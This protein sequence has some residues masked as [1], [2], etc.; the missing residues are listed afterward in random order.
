MRIALKILFTLFSI[1]TLFLLNEI[2]EPVPSSTTV[3]SNDVKL[4]KSNTI[5]FEVKLD[6][7]YQIELIPINEDILGNNYKLKVILNPNPTFL[8]KKNNVEIKN[9][10]FQLG[11]FCA[12]SGDDFELSINELDDRLR[13]KNMK[14]LITDYDAMPS[15]NLLWAH[16]LRPFIQRLFFICLSVTIL[17]GI[18]L[19]A[20]RIKAHNTK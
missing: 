2:W 3:F 20:I 14:L 16:E 19:F 1:I 6:G 7:C 12:E 18:L 9:G 4:K 8:E 15:Q 11:I 10:N 17:F 13:N 5:S